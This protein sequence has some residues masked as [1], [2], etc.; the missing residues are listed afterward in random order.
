MPNTLTKLLIHITFSTRNRVPTI[1]AELEPDLYSYIGGICRRMKSPLHAMNGTADHVH[2]LI[3]LDKNIALAPLLLN[4]KRDSSK[5]L[6][7][8]TPKRFNWQDGYFGFSIG[9]SG[10]E[11]LTKYIAKQ[12]PHHKKITFKEE[13]E[14]LLA[15]YKMKYDPHEIWD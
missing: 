8:R 15:K 1:P 5:W 11:V 6:N 13:V 10:V 9:E 14:A 7:E 12:K 4:I 2:M 3:S